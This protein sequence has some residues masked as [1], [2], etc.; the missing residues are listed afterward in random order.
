MYPPSAIRSISIKFH[1]NLKVPI[2][3]TR[4]SNSRSFL[5]F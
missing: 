5:E 4:F 3:F 1:Q 2:K